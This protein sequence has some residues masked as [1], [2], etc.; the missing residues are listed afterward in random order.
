MIGD[1]AERS[2]SLFVVLC[3]DHRVLSAIK[4]KVQYYSKDDLTT[5]LE[6]T[7]GQ[8]EKSVTDLGDKVRFIKTG[9]SSRIVAALLDVY[10]LSVVATGNCT[11]DTYRLVIVLTSPFKWTSPLILGILMQSLQLKLLSPRSIFIRLSL[12]T[13]SRTFHQPSTRLLI[14]DHTQPVRSH[15]LHKL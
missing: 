10:F 9:A 15:H 7:D 4:K 1:E 14:K 6:E 8:K 12:P 13:D 11:C 2:T 5:G 3:T